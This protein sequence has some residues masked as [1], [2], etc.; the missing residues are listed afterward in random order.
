MATADAPP[1]LGFSE[2]AGADTIAL[3]DG[4]RYIV[5][6]TRHAG[7]PTAKV[8]RI[9]GNGNLR[10]LTMATAR[11]GAAAA[12]LSIADATASSGSR[13]ALVVAGGSATGD[14]AEALNP[15]QDGFAALPI[16]ASSVAEHGL[17]SLDARTA[18]VAGGKD[19][20]TGDAAPV[21]VFDP[22]CTTGCTTSDL[23]M[24][25]TPLVRT[26]VFVVGSGKI[27]VVGESD[28]GQNHAYAVDTTA[29]PPMAVEQTLRE[30]RKEAK[31]LVLPNTLPGLV[32]G[33][34]LES[35]GP[36]LTI[37]AFVP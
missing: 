27:L 33:I 2:V 29:M 30:P 18:V 11:V 23:V 3:A 12:V 26:N 25:P 37:E 1:G 35:G 24:L 8:L 28:D 13:T 20:S 16:T 22:T 31:S 34:Q 32:G 19:L 15:N 17:A 21:R 5:G 6:A 36:A 4:T 9:D 10:A 14:W 7:D